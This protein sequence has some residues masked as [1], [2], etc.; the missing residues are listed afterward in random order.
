MPQ[1][2]IAETTMGWVYSAYLIV[3]TLLMT[4]G[5]LFID[6]FGARRALLLQ[7]FGSALFVLLTGLCGFAF[8]TGAAMV[9]GLIAVRACL[10]AV[11][12]PLHPAAAHAASRWIPRSGRGLANGLITCAAVLGVAA[13]YHLFGFLMDAVGWPLAFMVA[14][15][16]TGGVA[17]TWGLTAKDAPRDHPGVNEAEARLIESREGGKGAAAPEAP[18]GARLSLACLTLSYAGLG[19]FQY[20]FFYWMQHYFDKI[21]KVGTE[22]SRLYSMIATAAM[23]AGMAVGGSLADGAEVRFG[24][25]R[26]RAAV[27]VSGML[28]SAAFLLAGIL[29]DRVGWIL[30]FFSIAMASMG[31]VEAAFWT[32]AIEVGGRKA[33][34]AAAVMNTGN[35]FGGFLAPIVTPVTPLFAL[36]FGWK[37]GLGLACAFAAL[38][39]V[40][41]AWIRPPD[42][43]RGAA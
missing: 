24:R 35:N 19:Y 7:G 39:A 1:Y 43:G 33:A 42:P 29:N 23:A 9:I 16:V 26:G 28:L 20:L 12:A 2:G 22:R 17:L 14:G 41:W 30:A 5:G 11:N 21:L 34:T 32:T 3:Y 37:A 8:S 31:A 25:R 13:T 6:R 15:V 18:A 27:A 4:P 36:H 40:L 38:G 10:G